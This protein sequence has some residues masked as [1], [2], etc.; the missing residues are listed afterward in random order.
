M[1]H[2]KFYFSF[3]QLYHYLNTYHSLSFLLL[4][5]HHVFIYHLLAFIIIVLIFTYYFIIFHLSFQVP[6]IV[7]LVFAY[8]FLKVTSSSFLIYL[9]SFYR[10]IKECV[11]SLFSWPCLYLLVSRIYI[12]SSRLC[13][14]IPFM[15]LFFLHNLWIS[16]YLWNLDVS[17]SL[18]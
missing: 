13:T 1:K 7:L 8:H 14:F 5:I 10:L 2:M 15:K 4:I 16:S 11:I 12:F 6:F 3:Q 18:S 17:I 9:M